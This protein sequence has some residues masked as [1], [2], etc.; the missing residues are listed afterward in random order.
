MVETIAKMHL[1]N[2]LIQAIWRNFK[3]RRKKMSKIAIKISFMGPIIKCAAPLRN[4][5]GLGIAEIKNKIEN[6][7]FFAE[8]DTNDIDEMEKLKGLV[9]NLLKLGADVNIFDSDICGVDY[10]DISYNEFKNNIERLKEIKEEL[11]NY[12]DVLCDEI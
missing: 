3:G 11:Q 4:Y 2:L 12:D 6:K 10:Q 7:N 9:D 1:A 8:T 5:T